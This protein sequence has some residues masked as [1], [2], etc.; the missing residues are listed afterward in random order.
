MTSRDLA[1]TSP[2]EDL[3]QSDGSPMYHVSLER[4]AQLGRSAVALLAG[5][6]VE[7]C[8]SI[9]IPAHELDDPGAIIRE[10]AEHCAEDENFIHHNM[11]LQEIVFRTM[12]AHANNPLSLDKL[13][14]ELTERWSTPI[15]PIAISYEGLERVLDSDEY[16]GFA[17]LPE[18]D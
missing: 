15:R 6:R 1:P 13:H 2:G 16:Y 18:E 17:R 3:D 9:D 14:Y 10:I 5:R 11:A 8:P 7:A 4:L 12:L